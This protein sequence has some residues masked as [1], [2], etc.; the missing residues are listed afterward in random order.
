MVLSS[1]C[2]FR[3]IVGH[4]KWYR[5]AI[6]LVVLRWRIGYRAMSRNPEGELADGVR[7]EPVCHQP[8]RWLR[9]VAI[10]EYRY[11]SQSF[12]LSVQLHRLLI[13]F[14]SSEQQGVFL[15]S[16]NRTQLLPPL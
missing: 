4:L 16:V 10:P 14:A 13:T 8:R 3:A 9:Q 11:A 12:R 1:H 5:S 2:P 6:C 15:Q 7:E